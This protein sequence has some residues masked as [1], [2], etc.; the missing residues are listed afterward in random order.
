[1]L[2]TPPARAVPWI[3]F[4]TVVAV[5]REA[6]TVD[7]VTDQSERRLH[8]VPMA[9]PIFSQSFGEGMILMPEPGARAIVCLP[10]DQQ[11]PVILGFI[12]DPDES[13]DEEDDSYRAG[14]P[15]SQREE[16]AGFRGRKGNRISLFRDGTVLIQAKP[17]TQRLYLPGGTL[18]DVAS[19]YKIDTA[20]GRFDWH[21]EETSKEAKFVATFKARATDA[22]AT[23]AVRIGQLSDKPVVGPSAIDVAISPMSVDEHGQTVAE[24]YAFRVDQQGNSYE[25]QQGS[26]TKIVNGQVTITAATKTETITGSLTINVAGQKSENILGGYFLRSLAVDITAGSIQMTA[27]II[28]LGSPAAID[29]A[30]KGLELVKWLAT[31]THPAP[32][33]PP[34]D[35]IGDLPQILSTFLFLDPR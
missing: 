15:D 8:S 18:W 11:T 13:G 34:V 6:R 30:V 14:L 21:A 26:L 4:G 25:F 2:T 1:M 17:G 7:I 33:T 9:S 28:R 3:E 24:T 29:P 19:R 5:N 27:P 23:V 31:H 10:S 35:H 12:A 22:L 16:I 32:K 20:Q